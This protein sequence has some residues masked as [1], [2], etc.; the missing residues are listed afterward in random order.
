[1]VRQ[2]FNGQQ[3]R[4]ACAGCLMLV[5]FATGCT[6]VGTETRSESRF[7]TGTYEEIVNVSTEPTGCRIYVQDNYVGISPLKTSIQCGELKLT[8][9]GTYV[10]QMQYTHDAMTGAVVDRK[11]LTRFGT[12]W[13]EGLTPEISEGTYTIQAV[14]DG[15]NPARKTLTVNAQSDS[16]LQAV[17]SIQPNAEGRLNANV[18]GTRGVL[19]ILE[20]A[21]VV[22]T[23]PQQQQQQQ[24]Q[25]VIVIPQK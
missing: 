25:Q 14:H 20:P 6:T 23:P 13:N 17:R 8:Q 24:Q 4:Y 2:A 12:S 11:S 18:Q 21:P 5:L 1:M 22:Y 16:L 19:L 7:W 9:Q 10:E 15:F 3:V